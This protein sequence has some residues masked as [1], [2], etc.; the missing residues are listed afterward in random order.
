VPIGRWVLR[1]ACTQAVA[2][3]VD[4]LADLPLTVA[5][6]LS[7]RQLADPDLV[8][9]VRR[10]LAETGLE[11]ALLTLEI[12]ESVLMEDID[13]V[14]PSLHAL[15]N[16]GLRLAIDDFGTGYSSL[17]YLRRFPVD[18]LKI[19]K[20]LVDAAAAGDP[21][22]VALVRAI[23]DL[24]RSLQLTTVAEGVE[25]ETILPELIKIG[26]H[27]VQG[28]HFARPMPAADLSALLQRAFRPESAPDQLWEPTD[29]AG[30]TDAPVAV[31][32]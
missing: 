6:N 30:V 20:T 3:Q 11:P 23:V 9:D 28:F 21:G 14:L 25:N 2:W 7:V 18:I 17:A 26:C 29:P 32:R 22:G 8:S 16:L 24:G 27:S 1:E 10:V 12:T 31:D 13:E 5:V 19:D 15:K 4:I